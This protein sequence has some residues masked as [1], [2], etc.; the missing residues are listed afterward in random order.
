MTVQIDRERLRADVELGKDLT[1][2]YRADSVRGYYPAMDRIF[3]AVPQLLD[4]LDRVEAERDYRRRENAELV[5]EAKDERGAALD[6]IEQVRIRDARIT[7]WEQQYAQ[8]IADA[9]QATDEAEA[10]IKAVRRELDRLE[11]LALTSRSENIGILGFSWV[12]AIRRALD[13][14]R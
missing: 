12:T 3:E 13:G 5:Q 10:R 7:A 6:L 4:Q 9:N 14:D 2:T 11:V 1:G 8:D